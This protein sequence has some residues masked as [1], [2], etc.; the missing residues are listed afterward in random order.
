MN[1]MY[2]YVHT[3]LYLKY[4]Y[5]L[6]QAQHLN[7]MNLLLGKKLTLLTVTNFAPN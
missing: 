3:F 4:M 1:Y 2:R 6:I 7:A 5:I